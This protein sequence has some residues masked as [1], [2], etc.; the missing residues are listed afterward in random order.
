MKYILKVYKFCLYRPN[1]FVIKK[2]T[3]IYRPAKYS[4][5][6]YAYTILA[7]PLFIFITIYFKF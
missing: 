7:R 5:K 1:I 3:E 2:L 4:T 6:Y